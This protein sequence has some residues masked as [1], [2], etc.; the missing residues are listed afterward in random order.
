MLANFFL[1]ILQVWD[2]IAL[3]GTEEDVSYGTSKLAMHQDEIYYDGTP[4]I[5]FF[6]CLRY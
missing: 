6:H 1:V 5:T 4:G 3:E 2:V